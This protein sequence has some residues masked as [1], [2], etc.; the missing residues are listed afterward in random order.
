MNAWTFLKSYPHRR[1]QANVYY[2]TGVNDSLRHVVLSRIRNRLKTDSTYVD[3]K[4]TK[5]E[6]D[7]ISALSQDVISRSRYVELACV[8]TWQS[9]SLF[10]SWLRTSLTSRVNLVLTSI[11]KIKTDNE[12]AQ[13]VISKG[14]FVTCVNPS[15]ET[16]V[17]YVMTEYHLDEEVTSSLVFLSGDDYMRI[18]SLLLKTYHLTGGKV[19]NIQSVKEASVGYE[20]GIFPLVELVLEGRAVIH[21][22]DIIEI[23][24]QSFVTQ[25]RRRLI[26]LMI[27]RALKDT[28][29]SQLEIAKESGVPIYRLRESF[30]LAMLFTGPEIKRWLGL[31]AE[32]ELFL[33]K[34]RQRPELAIPILLSKLRSN[35]AN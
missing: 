33:Q 13:Y 12:L 30:N 1:P 11:T 9:N 24:P 3:I 31:I 34:Y 10:T 25:L 6:Y 19:P 21:Y 26:Q 17:D 15:F 32:T 16:L 7:A 22:D 14:W 4:D 29:V 2:V 23:Q 8:D 35:H 18:K 28:N 5:S 20:S 27:V